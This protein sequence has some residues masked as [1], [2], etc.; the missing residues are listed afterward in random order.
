MNC[1]GLVIQVKVSLALDLQ[2]MQQ[3]HFLKL[4]KL[5]LL[6]NFIMCRCATYHK[7]LFFCCSNR[8]SVPFVRLLQV[9]SNG[10]SATTDVQTVQTAENAQNPQQQQ[11]QPAPNAWQVIK[12]V[13]FRWAFSPFSIVTLSTIII[14]NN[15]LCILYYEY[16]RV[17]VKV[18]DL[19]GDGGFIFWL[20]LYPPPHPLPPPQYINWKVFYL[21]LLLIIIRY[22][23]LD[24]I[25][26]FGGILHKYVYTYRDTRALHVTVP[27]ATNCSLL[28]LPQIWSIS[29]M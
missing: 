29:A 17:W 22:Y 5:F 13:L 2:W 7:C 27:H 14:I 8:Y 6:G 9:S 28:S 11:Q 15:D 21:S 3:Q 12:G 1:G 25:S 23:V 4:L 20:A 18:G 19:L 10:T 26:I 24:L 16:V